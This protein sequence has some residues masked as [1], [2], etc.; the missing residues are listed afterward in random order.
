MP[1]ICNISNPKP[2][3]YNCPVCK[4]TG[5]LPNMAGRFFIKSLS[6]CYCNGCNTVFEK[7]RFYK[8]IVTTK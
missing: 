2:V 3:N 4:L 5:Q 1:K 6:E 8:N 7:S